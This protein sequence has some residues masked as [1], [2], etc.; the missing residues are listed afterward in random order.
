MAAF[1]SSGPSTDYER[2]LCQ[3][4]SVHVFRVRFVYYIMLLNTFIYQ[5]YIRDR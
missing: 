4:P 5:D 1:E 3:L 2:T